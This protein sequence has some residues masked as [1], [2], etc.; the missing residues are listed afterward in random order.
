ME[1]TRV[2]GTSQLAGEAADTLA[3]VHHNDAVALVF[4]GGLGRA[5][6]GALRDIAVIAQDRDKFTLASDR[7]RHLLLQ[8]VRAVTIRGHMIGARAGLFA[9][10]GIVGTDNLRRQHIA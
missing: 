8:D 1:V 4:I 5:D 3:L 2:V 10:L 6:P 7:F 9:A